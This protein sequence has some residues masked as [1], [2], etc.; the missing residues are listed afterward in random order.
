[1]VIDM[2][3]T[4]CDICGKEVNNS[5]QFLDASNK[6]FFSDTDDEPIGDVCGECYKIICCCINMMKETKWK[7]DFH[8]VLKSDD[9]WKRDIA[10]YKLCD[11]EK[12]FDIEF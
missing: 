5:I 2:K 11:L 4:Y 6:F 10:G 12:K 3:K 9:I 1:M 7:P 8:E